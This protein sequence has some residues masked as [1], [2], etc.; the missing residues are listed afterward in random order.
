[1]GPGWGVWGDT[2]VGGYRMGDSWCGTLDSVWVLISA[3]SLLLCFG[4]FVGGGTTTW[5]FTYYI[6]FK[7]SLTITV[8]LPF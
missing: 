2:S 3:S 8:K 4:S 1:M 6:M 7:L 5:I